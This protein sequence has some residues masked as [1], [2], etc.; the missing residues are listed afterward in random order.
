MTDQAVVSGATK[1][2]YINEE[3]EKSWW[4]KHWYGIL[5]AVFLAVMGVVFIVS[6]IHE[7]R[8]KRKQRK[9]GIFP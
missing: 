9:Q 7:Q 6:I 8:K 5:I 3:E 2:V 1:D 4:S